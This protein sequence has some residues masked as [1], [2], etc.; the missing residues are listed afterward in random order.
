M[1]PLLPLLAAGIIALLKQRQRTV[2]ATLSIGSLAGSLIL[3]ISAFINCSN[4]G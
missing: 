1:I 4:V 3:S 2:A